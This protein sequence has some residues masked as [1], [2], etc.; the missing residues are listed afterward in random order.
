MKNKT[1]ADKS[2]A[3]E[4]VFEVGTEGGSLS[5]K[6]FRAADGT[7]KFILYRNESAMADFLD[8]EDQLELT[9][10]SEGLST[11]EKALD[12]SRQCIAYIQPPVHRLQM[13]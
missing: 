7:W 13:L 2:G 12:A 9:S 10:Q 1:D 8:E 5:I 6:R 11:F 4:I 3:E